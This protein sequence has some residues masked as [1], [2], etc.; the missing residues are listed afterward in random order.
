[1]P[2]WYHLYYDSIPAGHAY[3]LLVEHHTVPLETT[4]GQTDRQTDRHSDRHGDTNMVT[5]LFLDDPGPTHKAE[6]IVAELSH[7]QFP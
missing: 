5:Y 3:T 4:G 7:C 2:Y 6:V 1:M